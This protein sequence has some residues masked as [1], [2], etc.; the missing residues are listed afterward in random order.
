MK[1]DVPPFVIDKLFNQGYQ[2]QIIDIIMACENMTNTEVSDIPLSSTLMNDS[3]EK[4]IISPKVYAT[5]MN[6]VQRISD[7]ATAQEIPFFLLGNKKDI[8]G[9]MCIVIENIEY[10]I[11][12]ALSE[13]R[14]QMDEDRFQQLLQDE[15]YSIIS[16]GHT[17]GNVVEEKK[18]TTLARTLPDDIKERY[19]I[20]DTG[21]NVSV[22]DIWQHEVVKEIAKQTST[23]EVMQTIIMYNGDMIMISANGISKSNEIQTILQDGSYQSIQTGISEQHTNKQVR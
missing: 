17:H 3:S 4:V 6:L 2:D 23:K 15:K 11:E 18:K 7:S 16:I 22:A 19:D 14:V 5:Y 1:N 13:N 21:L 9:E 20:R 12:K 10:D 8:D